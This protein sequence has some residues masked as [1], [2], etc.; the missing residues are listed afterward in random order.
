MLKTF[1]KGVPRKISN[2]QTQFGMSSTRI[3][4]SKKAITS[5]DSAPVE[6]TKKRRKNIKISY[7]DSTEDDPKVESEYFK[8]T[9]SQWFPSDWKLI[10]NN[11]QK[12]RNK[13]DAPV[14]TM[15]CEQCVN[16]EDTDKVYSLL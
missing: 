2:H 3:T 10:L 4:R 13:F 9:L 7:D 16:R 12:M 5:T 14:D 8:S 11:I 6:T 1:F 15:G